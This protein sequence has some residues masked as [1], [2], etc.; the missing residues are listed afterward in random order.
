MGFWR[1]LVG[2]REEKALNSIQ[3]CAEAIRETGVA[4]PN[5]TVEDVEKMLR[6]IYPE[7]IT[8]RHIYNSGYPDNARRYGAIFHCEDSPFKSCYQFR[9]VCR[10][11]R[12]VVRTYINH[13]VSTSKGRISPEQDLHNWRWMETGRAVTQKEFDMLERHCWQVSNGV[14]EPQYKKYMPL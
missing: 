9:V 3:H 1:R 5:M 11:W 7:R 2:F 13:V 6:K 10:P 12:G 4:S 8:I 14:I